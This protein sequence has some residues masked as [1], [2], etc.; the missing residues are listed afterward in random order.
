MRYLVRNEL[1]FQKPVNLRRLSPMMKIYAGIVSKWHET[2]YYLTN[3]HKRQEAAY[4]AQVQ[5]DE[6]LKEALLVQIFKELNNNHSMKAKG[7]ECDEVILCVQSKFIHS[8]D[9]ILT[10]KDFLPYIIAKVP[11]DPD[12]RLAFP[13]MPVLVKVQ[14]KKLKGVDEELVVTGHET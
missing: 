3:L 13:E 12:I 6:K 10:H 14:K 8:L 4:A 9:R 1:D 7:E 2:N 11:E 5:R